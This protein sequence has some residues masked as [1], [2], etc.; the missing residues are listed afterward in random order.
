MTVFL[1]TERLI[2]K[3]PEL[4]DFDALF[5]LRSD[6][7]VMK[8]IGDGCIHTKEKV[9]KFL[10]M[11]IPYY[12]KHGIGFCSVF[13]KESGDFIGQAGLFNIGYDDT[14][15][16]IE[17]AYRLHKK[18]WGKGY[19]T[20]LTKALIEWGFRNLSINKLIGVAS[21]ENIASQK[22]LQKSGMDARGKIKWYTGQELFL[23][24]IYKN[25]AIEL[26]PYDDQ[27]P[28]LAKL[29]ITTLQNSLPENHIIDIQHVGS[30]AIPGMIAKPIIDIQIAVDSISAIKQ[31]A[32]ETLKTLGYEYWSDNPDLERLFFVK[33]M[34]PFGEKRTHHVH[35]VEPSSKHWKEKIL[36]RDYLISDP[37]VADEYKKLKKKL[38]EQHQYDRERYTDSKTKFVNDVLQ[39][40]RKNASNDN[41][42]P[43][44]D[45][46]L[47]SHLVATQFPQWKDLPIKPVA[48]S[49]WDNRTFHL[50]DHLLVRMPSAADYALQVEKEHQ[51]LPILAPLLP[52]QIPVPLAI[53]EPAEGYPWRWSIYQWIEGE[54]AASGYIADMRDFATSLA[55]FFIALHHIDSRNG[56]RPGL[57][58][59]YR[60]GSLATYDAQTR[61]A[62]TMLK[63]KIDI[64]ATTKVW[65]TAL[66]TTWNRPPV[67]VH[68]DVSIGNLLV[69]NGRL[70]AV[71]DFGQ[72]TIGDPA[73]DLAIAWTF[74]HSESRK[75]FR[76]LLS[77]DA[78][79]WA[80]GR[81][82]TLWKALIVAAGL[83]NSIKTEVE[84]CWRIINEV[85]GDGL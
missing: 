83:T 59:F 63:D 14:K 82:W 32:I 53:G 70:S 4:S 10:E 79:T 77:L 15:P 21:P 27:W 46:A 18:F 69:K 51:W 78:G 20:E 11:A 7:D 56:P 8:Y 64:D 66:A 44:I 33:G 61:Q 38:A 28:I 55:Q 72:L 57:H 22:V 71:I 52:L 29:E 24:E 75:I 3:T 39:K 65:E 84:Q 37:A 6:P 35:I 48:V 45:S 49:G 1:E 85:L 36:F 58:S 5:T 68:G 73:C 62:I 25:D 13:E 41:G 42:Q 81:G 43:I 50:G 76:S 74:F 31:T 34:P 67:W 17:I 40:V 12:E 26:T 19:A 30:T 60:G 47:A 9:E 80:R 23:Y 2:L 54:T 16:D